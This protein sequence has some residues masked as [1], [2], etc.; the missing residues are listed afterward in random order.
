MIKNKL[1]V[2]IPSFK[3]E[4]LLTRVLTSLSDQ[5]FKHFETVIL[6]DASGCDFGLIEKTFSTKLHLRIIRNPINVGAMQNIYNSIFYACDTEYV[7]SLHED[8]YLAD[9]YIENALSILN[10]NTNVLFVSTRPEWIQKNS[11][12]ERFSQES[13]LSHKNTHYFLY[14]DRQLSLAFIRMEHIMFSS[15]VYRRTALFDAWDYK[16][17][18]TFCDR[19]FLLQIL[20]RGEGLCAQIIT[21]GIRVRDHSM[22]QHDHRGDNAH[23]YHFLRL[24]FFYLRSIESPSKLFINSFPIIKYF[25][26]GIISFLKRYLKSL[27]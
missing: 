13:I 15:I 27:Y 8:D 16:T 4:L 23:F 12:Y 18:N 14:S 5:T 7:L 1:T 17:Y 24:V 3:Q 26:V 19:V 22:D 25:L 2:I 6:D 21:P 10:K 9:N 11:T 20:K